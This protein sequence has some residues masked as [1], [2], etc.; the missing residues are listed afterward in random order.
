M[1]L[2]ESLITLTTGV[3][4]LTCVLAVVGLHSYASGRAQRQALVDRLAATGQIP[5]RR[6]GAASAAWTADCAA[7][8][9][10][11]SWNCAWRPPGLDV[12]PG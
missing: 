2:P 9:S 12:T 6:A 1:D 11:G 3:T 4:L 8:S 7:P 5:G 10:A